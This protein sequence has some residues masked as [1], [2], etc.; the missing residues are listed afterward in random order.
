MNMNQVTLSCTNIE[1]SKSFYTT[2]GLTLI[3]DTPHYLR[4]ACPGNGATIS[5][6]KAEQISEGVKVYFEEQQLDDKVTELSGLGIQIVQFP[7]D[8][9]YLWREAALRDPS[10]NKL[11]LFWAGENRIN[12]PWRV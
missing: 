10:G 3:V 1:A 4:L 8:K 9:S 5:L 6:Q 7:E 2:L 12:P 11:I